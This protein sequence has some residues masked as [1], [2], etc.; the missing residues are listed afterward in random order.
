MVGMD[1][2]AGQVG[3]EKID[4]VG[5]VH[6]KGR[7]PDEGVRHLHWRDR[8]TV[9]QKLVR[10]GTHPRAPCSRR[11]ARDPHAARWR[12][13]LGV[14]YTAAPIVR[15]VRMPVRK[16]K[17]AASVRSAQWRRA[18]ADAAADD[19][20]VWPRSQVNSR[21]KVPHGMCVRERPGHGVLR[22]D[23]TLAAR[24]AQL[25]VCA[26]VYSPSGRSPNSS[27]ATSWTRN[28]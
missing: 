26:N 18:S 20:D 12:T 13:A 2:P 24:P 23:A 19:H 14:T 17:R 8:R 1:D 25:G 15:P 5:A 16:P 21:E 11:R 3:R 9:V 7:V 4:E 28:A 27:T 6:A 22:Q 10:A